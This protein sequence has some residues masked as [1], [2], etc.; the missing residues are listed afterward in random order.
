[1]VKLNRDVP[2]VKMLDEFVHGR[3]GSFILEYSDLSTRRL[4]HW[5][6]VTHTVNWPSLVQITACHLVIYIFSFKKLHWKV[7]SWKWWPFCLVLNV[8]NEISLPCAEPV[9]SQ[10]SALGHSLIY[11]F[12]TRKLLISVGCCVIFCQDLF[13]HLDSE[14]TNVNC[15]EIL[16]HF[17]HVSSIKLH[18]NQC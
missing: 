5:G 11:Y 9:F 16:L 7:L 18:S 14:F 6:R 17:I 1:M 2:W 8:L 15:S 12:F 10:Y 13:G 3:R 4:T